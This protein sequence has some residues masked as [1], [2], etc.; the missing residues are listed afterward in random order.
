MTWHAI[1]L[2]PA[3]EQRD[4]VAEFLVAHTGHAVQERDD[5]TLVT[6]VTDAPA[7]DRLERELVARFGPLD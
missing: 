5:G 7:A 2:R 4:A 6:V 3:S 1:E